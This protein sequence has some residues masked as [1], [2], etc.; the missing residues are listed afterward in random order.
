MA[1]HDM[2]VKIRFHKGAWWLFIHHRS[3]RRAKKIGDR[4]TPLRTA[5]QVREAIVARRN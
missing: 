3:Q 5:R 2:G 1:K 4:E